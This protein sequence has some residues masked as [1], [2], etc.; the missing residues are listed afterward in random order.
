VHFGEKDQ[1][2]PIDGVR[3]IAAAHPEVEVHIFP[4]ERHHD[5]NGGVRLDGGN[6]HPHL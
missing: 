3:E 5:R 4:A 1:H 2:I 6:V